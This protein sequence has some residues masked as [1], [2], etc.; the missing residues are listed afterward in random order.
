M[1]LSEAIRR[2]SIDWC[3]LDWTVLQLAFRITG[4]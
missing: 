4:T 3:G 2:P 1:Q